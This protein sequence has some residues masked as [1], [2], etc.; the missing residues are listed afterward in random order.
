MSG[1]HVGS[2]IKGWRKGLRLTQGELGEAVGVR[3]ATISDWERGVYTVDALHWPQL[4]RALRLSP[5]EVSRLQQ[6][7]LHQ[8]K[9]AA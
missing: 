2:L 5:A 4:A 1:E 7:I 8:Y 6:A 3:Q 9:P